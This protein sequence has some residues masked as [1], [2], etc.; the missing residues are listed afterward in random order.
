MKK[1]VILLAA[2]VTLASCSKTT[3]TKEDIQMLQSK[4]QTVYALDHHGWDYVVC[5]SINVYHI[6]MGRTGNIETKI[7][8]K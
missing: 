3:T 7:K 5:D 6:T 4:F 1:I 8:I 2:V